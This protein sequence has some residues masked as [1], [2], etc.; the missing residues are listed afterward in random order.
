MK[1]I[2]YSTMLS[3]LITLVLLAQLLSGCTNKISEDK[4]YTE[5]VDQIAKEDEYVEECISYAEA[6]NQLAKA[7]KYDE[8]IGMAEDATLEPV[9]QAEAFTKIADNYAEDGKKD[10]AS[11]MIS[12]A[13]EAAEKMR[14]IGSLN[15]Y[16][17]I[18]ILK[19]IANIYIKIGQTGNTEDILSKA[20][21]LA[22]T[23]GEM[24]DEKEDDY[25]YKI[26][27]Y[28]YK[29]DALTEIASD[30]AKYGQKEKALDIT[31]Q[32]LKIA[33][34]V[35]N[36]YNRAAE[37]S[38]I[39]R[40]YIE[41]GQ[42]DKSLNILTQSYELAKEI[43]DNRNKA[44]ILTEI[45][46]NYTKA[47][48]EDKALEIANHALKLAKEIGY[49]ELYGNVLVKI[50]HIYKEI[51]QEEK[52]L[53]IYKQALEIGKKEASEFSMGEMILIK[54]KETYENGW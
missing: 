20:I 9:I 10:N 31:N 42:I 15:R 18:I 36:K 6:V 1:K 4:S 35:A 2:I 3:I 47:G 53:D 21:E 7:G 19:E 17:K 22:M 25:Y 14:N 24:E 27:T 52:A 28:Y 13:L 12:R 50:A 44:Y 16:E 46:Y 33:T 23:I 38:K 5:D 26:D 51:G 49:D 43:K 11:E 8:A 29:I 41:L 54:I 40:N 45:A 34:E 39:A 32:A 37:L 48:K 30:Y